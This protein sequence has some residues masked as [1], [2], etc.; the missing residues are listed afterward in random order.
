MSERSDEYELSIDGLP[1][2]I[3]R[4]DLYFDSGNRITDNVDT[5]DVPYELYPEEYFVDNIIAPTR[6]GLL[7]NKKVKAIFDSLDIKNIQYLNVRLL[8]KN[9]QSINQNYY[10]AN[11][12]GKYACVDKEASKLELFDDGDIQ[13]INKLV[14]NI[15]NGKDYG[16]IFR[17]SE[18]PSIL[19]ISDLLKTALAQNNVAG[20]K[21]YKPELFSL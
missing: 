7:I 1:P 18:F 2:D 12:V 17:L 19:I 11:V 14:L 4:L 3:E 5:I 9:T 15:N 21:I 10:I 6:L 20:F 8:E 13:F 16:H